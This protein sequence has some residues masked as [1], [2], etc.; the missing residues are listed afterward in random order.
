MTVE[1]PGGRLTLDAAYVGADADEIRRQAREYREGRRR[2]FD[3]PVRYP[4]GF[5]GRVMGAM[6]AIPYGETRTYGEVA[7]DL[8]SAPQ[9]VGAACGRNPIPLVVPCHRVVAADGVGGYSAEGG[10]ELKRRLLDHERSGSVQTTL[11]DADGDDDPGDGD[12]FAPD[13]GGGSRP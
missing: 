8:D 7:A 12:G 1:V 5:T 10:P 3:L 2:E 13:G 6:A 9:A 4:N 11:A